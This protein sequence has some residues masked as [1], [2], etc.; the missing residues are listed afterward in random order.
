[1]SMD[2]TTYYMERAIERLNIS[3]SLAES[4]K[5]PHRVIK[6]EITFL[7]DNGKLVN[8]TGYRIQH[9]N[10]L[11]PMKGGL[12]YHP[13]VNEDELTSL[14]SLMTWKTSLL[15]LPFGGA[16]GGICC[17]PSKLSSSE[18]ERLTKTF[19][20]KIKDLIGP[21]KDIL[22][23]DVNTNAQT[24]AW[25]MAEYSKTVGFSPGVVTGKPVFLYGSEGRE[26]ATGNGIAIVTEKL[27]SLDK[28]KL[29][30]T[31]I[32]IQGFGNVGSHTAQALYEKGAKIIAISDVKGGIFQK[33]GIDIPALKKH[34]AET[35]SV[36]DFP[37]SD[38]MTNSQLLATECDVLIPAA[39]GNVF[40]KE[41]AKAV[42][43]Q[44]IIE[45]ANG[46]T[47]PEGDEIFN[48]RGIKVLPDIL[49]NSAG[50]TVSYF[51]WV[52]NIQKFKWTLE[53]VQS[54]LNTFITKA[55]DS[56]IHIA[57]SEHCSY[58]EAAFFI[59]IKRVMESTETLGF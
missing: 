26:A 52:Q 42:N 23:P 14:A 2:A 8:Y 51:E 3:E 25:I 7:L 18:L 1:M 37:G 12:R 47:L 48:K 35:G 15:G 41:I 33:K 10:A 11:G 56:V 32:V 5:L 20:D 21:S 28:K 39:L 38:A 17:D 54:Q 57:N 36:I 6:T 9:N 24:M 30:D 13:T 4:L 29:K 40:D 53:E 50:V 16:K 58:R 34:V 31:R 44:Y 55:F 43:C 27:L 45:A 59:S 49:A 22:A 19:I 46:P